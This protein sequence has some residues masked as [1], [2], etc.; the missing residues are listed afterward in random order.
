MLKDC[1][2]LNKVI[3]PTQKCLAPDIYSACMPGLPP[4]LSSPWKRQLTQIQF[5]SKAGNEQV[6]IPVSSFGLRSRRSRQLF[7]F[8]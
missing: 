6:N 8:F 7:F 4:F 2:S 5:I 3:S 1:L